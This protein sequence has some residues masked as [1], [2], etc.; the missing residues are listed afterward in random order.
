MGGGDSQDTPASGS[1]GVN[2]FGGSAEGAQ[3]H[4]T[5]GAGAG[6][7]DW[8]DG[9]GQNGRIV[10]FSVLLSGRGYV[11]PLVNLYGRRLR[12]SA[13][14][15]ELRRTH[16]GAFSVD[17]AWSWDALLPLL[18][19]YGGAAAGRGQQQGGGGRGGGRGR[20]GVRVVWGDKGGRQR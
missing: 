6:G 17:D 2:D 19:R 13:V 18:Q 15:D 1:G 5:G 7:V 11:R 3:G 12:T 8:R 14:L 9:G 16:V 20:G 10:R 4:A